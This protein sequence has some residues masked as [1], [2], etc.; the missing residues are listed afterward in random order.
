MKL[1]KLLATCALAGLAVSGQAF[2]QAAF[3]T[4]DL[5]VNL[6]GA[7]APDNFLQG[8]ATAIYLPG[9]HTYQDDG[10]TPGVFTDDGLGWR[11]FFGTLAST[12]D[13]PVALR[14][15]RVLFIK[16][17]AGGS[18][19]GVDPVARAGRH[20]TI[21]ITDPTCELNASIQRCTIIGIDPGLPN[22][23]DPVLNNGR[24]SDF[25]VSDVEP[26]LFKAPYNVEFGQGQLTPAEAARLLVK[27]V[28]VLMMGFSATNAVPATTYLSRADYAAMLSNRI[29]DWSQVDPT[30]TTGN[31][32]VVVCRR[33]NGSGTQSS[34]NWFFNN[35][36]CQSAFGGLVAPAT[37]LDDSFSG[38]VAG[39]GLSSAT[40]FEIDPSQGYTVVDNS[41]S[42]N[43]RTCLTNAQS[44]TDLTFLGANGSWYK[45]LFSAGGPGNPYRAIGVLSVDSFASATVGTVG[46]PPTTGWSFRSMD[47]AGIFDARSTG[48]TAQL[49][50]N[51]PG[52]GIAPSKVNLLTG[53][54]DFAV[55]L[56]MQYRTVPVTNLQ[57]DV[58]P[59][60][61]GLRLAFADEFI[62]R[63]GDPSRNTGPVTAA[64][65]PTFTPTLDVNG[66]PT[67]NV[68]KGT[69]GGNTCKPLGRLF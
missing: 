28:N 68:A 59:A 62:R 35:F 43:V 6:T 36:P 16:R 48:A 19:W 21:N 46:V 47:G 30:I 52:T 57:G 40:A 56:A 1:K 4:P 27:P 32:Q 39:D 61:S 26:N 60:L 3:D 54:Y 66:V 8:I 63:A 38:I 34:Y 41:S 22:H 9:F 25:G 49:F 44:N 10:G 29:Q 33:V 15:Q 53:K 64:L 14:G 20:R 13:I 23:A 7:S 12:A 65:P 5:T 2:G 67:N 50:T 69:R 45:I 17:S 58:V 55:E 42:G 18:V 24:V 11:A 51:G 37:M 31:T